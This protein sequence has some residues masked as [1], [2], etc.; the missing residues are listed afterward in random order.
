C[1]R[2]PYRLHVPPAYVPPAAAHVAG[3][4][5]AQPAVPPAIPAATKPTISSVCRAIKR[6]PRRRHSRAD[7]RKSVALRFP[8][9]TSR[10]ARRPPGSLGHSLVREL[11][12]GDVLD[13]S[14]PHT[15]M[16]A[17]FRREGA[18]DHDVPPIEFSSP[19]IDSLSHVDSDTIGHNYVPRI[20]FA[21][22]E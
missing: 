10:L 12:L 4:S 17:S 3:G 6:P 21:D 16:S 7:L 5:R 2:W 20:S 14:F 9:P 13:P 8:P 22:V 19:L 18:I 1:C 11:Y 15:K